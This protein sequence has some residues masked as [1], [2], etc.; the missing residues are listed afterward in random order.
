MTGNDDDL[1][2]DEL[3]RE[4]SFGPTQHLRDALPD[5]VMEELNA[6]VWEALGYPGER[7]HGFRS[8]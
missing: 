3:M 2:I 6:K 1:D 4:S 5:D 8:P 7:R